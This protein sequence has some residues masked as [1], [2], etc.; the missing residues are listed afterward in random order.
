MTEALSAA[1]ATVAERRGC[2]IE[3]LRQVGER[4]TELGFEAS[5]AS[6]VEVPKV[7]SKALEVQMLRE[8][9]S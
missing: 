6:L 7:T 1:M 3:M 8:F 5:E 9:K 4:P 2:M